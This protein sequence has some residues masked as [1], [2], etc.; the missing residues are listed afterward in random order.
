MGDS[1]RRSS[2]FRPSSPPSFYHRPTWVI[3][4]LVL[5][6]DLLV[7]TLALRVILQYQDL[8]FDWDEATH[9]TG[10]LVLALDLQAGD[11]PA[12]VRDSYAQGNY[13]PAFSWLLAPVLSIVGPARAAARAVSL[14]CLSLAV[15]VI[16]LVGL[17]LD[18]KRGWAIYGITVILTL[19]I[20]VI[21]PLLEADSSG[22]P[23]TGA[24]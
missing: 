19:V 14:L 9:A 5:L 16:T 20:I 24:D 23:P 6:A 17:E 2:V 12:F 13:P 22:P 7:S 15:I 4:L 3:L 10:G 11:L 1:G 8:P 18:E 21:S